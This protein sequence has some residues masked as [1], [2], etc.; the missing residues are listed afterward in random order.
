MIAFNIILL[1]NIIQL[2]IIEY[3]EKKQNYLKADFQNLTPSYCTLVLVL[4]HASDLFDYF[5]ACRKRSR[6]KGNI[7]I[8]TQW[9][10]RFQ[11]SQTFPKT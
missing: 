9:R 4:F 8:G 11:I 6:L 7:K 2:I 3:G 10:S 1:V 5:P